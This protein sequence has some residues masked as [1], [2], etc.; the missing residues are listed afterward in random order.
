MTDT[1]DFLKIMEGDPTLRVEKDE[2]AE[3]KFF[4]FANSQSELTSNAEWLI[5]R[6]TQS[7][8][9]EQIIWASKKLDQIWDD[10]LTLFG[11]SPFAN[12]NSMLFNNLDTNDRLPF[13]NHSSINFER[14]V[15]WSASGWF[16]TGKTNSQVIVGKQSGTNNPGWRLE[17]NSNVIRFHIAAASGSRI[18]LRSSVSGLA[19]GFWHHVVATYD[20]SS[21]ASGCKL[22]ID[23]VKDLAPTIQVDTLS[24]GGGSIINGLPLQICG[25]NESNT[26]VFQG[27]LDEIAVWDIELSEAN[28]LALFGSGE[29][30][31][32]AAHP[33]VLNM[34]FWARLGENA[35]WPVIPNIGTVGAALN[36]SAVSMIAS[37]IT[38]E[39][40]KVV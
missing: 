15:P 5:A 32:L 26:N 37:A 13:S 31:N 34:P 25:R 27:F 17:A 16:R 29:P 38:S 7:G 11:A 18:E 30:T 36:G 39:T 2:F 20:G 8:T 33:N 9:A 35:A 10:R 24:G 40:A 19:D 1:I 12:Q 22:F 6:F 23:G 14:T 3:F 4:G 21:L 28:A